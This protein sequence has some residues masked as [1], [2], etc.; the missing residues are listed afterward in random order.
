VAAVA[1][2]AAGVDAVRRRRQ[3]KQRTTYH[4][5]PSNDRWE[6]RGEGAQRA[7]SVHETKRQAVA[8]ARELARGKEPS[9]LV[10]HRLDGTVQDS[11]V[12]G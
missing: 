9:K 7:S 8:A 6:V 5:V 4:V 2:A 1:V 11:F 10:V 12:Y 3:A